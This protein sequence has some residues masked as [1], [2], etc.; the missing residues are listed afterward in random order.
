M[1][2]LN[3]R[4]CSG[5]RYRVFDQRHRSAGANPGSHRFVHQKQVCCHLRHRYRGNMYR[6]SDRVLDSINCDAGT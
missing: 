2:I 6:I 4:I 1:L 3:I 5:F